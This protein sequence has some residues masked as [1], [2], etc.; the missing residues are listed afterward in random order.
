[1]H[2]IKHYKT[3][4]DWLNKKEVFHLAIRPVKKIDDLVKINNVVIS[5]SDKEGIQDFAKSLVVINPA[6]KIY[7]TGGTFNV[8]KETVGSHVEEVSS[9]TDMPETE[10]G[11]VKTLHHKLFL[12]YLTETY[13]EGHQ[14]DLEREKAKPIDMVVSN[15]YPFPEDSEG[16]TFEEMRG[17][18]DIGGPSMVRASAKNFHRIATIVEPGDYQEVLRE[19]AMN[20]GCIGIETR[21]KLFKKAFEHTAEYDVRIAMYN[22]EVKLEDVLKCYEVAK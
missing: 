7:S 9:Y 10:G 12:G 3:K 1:M 21:F 17:L 15:L 16:K 22:E 5:V 18:I 6:V 20:E 14:R 19:L 2:E 4:R 13:C 11:L 8:L